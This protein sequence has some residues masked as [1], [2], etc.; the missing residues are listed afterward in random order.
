MGSRLQCRPRGDSHPI[1]STPSP[2]YRASDRE[3]DD[4]FP[5]TNSLFVQDVI[6]MER[7]QKSNKAADRLLSLNGPV[8]PFWGM[9]SGLKQWRAAWPRRKTSCQNDI[10]W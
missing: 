4:A 2:P 6:L 5:Y 8:T 3:D 9:A 10:V 1:P 7:P